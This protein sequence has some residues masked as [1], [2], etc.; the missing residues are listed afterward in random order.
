MAP[1]PGEFPG[2]YRNVIPNFIA[3]AFAGRPLPITG[4]GAER[5]TFTYVEDVV[6]LLAALGRNDAAIGQTVKVASRNDL[7]VE[8]MAAAV[9]RLT[10]NTAGVEH[11]PRRAWDHVIVRRA[12]LARLQELVPDAPSTAF[13]DGLERTVAWAERHRARFVL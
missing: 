10:G 5:R 11:H 12:A 4:T 7:A 9:N 1:G 6:T 2:R 8:T 13:E 3:H